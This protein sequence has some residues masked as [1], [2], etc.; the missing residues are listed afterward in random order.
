MISFTAQRRSFRY[1][2]ISKA[3]YENGGKARDSVENTRSSRTAVSSPIPRGAFRS[4]R[5]ARSMLRV[6]ER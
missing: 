1:A 3:D 2:F 4:Q 5:S 6:S